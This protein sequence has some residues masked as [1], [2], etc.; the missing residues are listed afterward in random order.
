MREVRIGLRKVNLACVIFTCKH[1]DDFSMKI[2]GCLDLK[3]TWILQ[4]SKWDGY[5]AH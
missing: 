4:Q 3:K 2:D 1:H 5:T